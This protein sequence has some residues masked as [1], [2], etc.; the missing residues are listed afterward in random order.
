[1]SDPSFYGPGETEFRPWGPGEPSNKHNEQCTY[2]DY[3][4]R[5][6]D[7]DCNDRT[8]AVCFDVTGPNAT[9]VLINSLMTWT[10]AQSYCREHHT[11]L[12]SVRNQTEHQQIFEL[13]PGGNPYWIGLYRDSWK[14]SQSLCGCSFRQLWKM[15]GLGL[16]S[17]ET[18]HLL[19]TCYA[20][21]NE[22]DKGEGGE[23]RR[24]GSERPRFSGCDVG[25]GEKEPKG[26]GIGRQ[27]PTGLEEAAGWKSL[28][29]G[30]GG[31]EEG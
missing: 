19:R 8:W 28:P 25:G 3:D 29:Q 16:W 27:R 13:F 20:C 30:G 26:P 15:G 23:T 4:G 21:F 1:M 10:Q 12:A 6:H 2:F 5:W 22:S 9:F 31:E 24:C 18:I 17:E 14:W 7:F 11:D